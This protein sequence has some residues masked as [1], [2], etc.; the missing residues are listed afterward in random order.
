MFLLAGHLKKHISE[1][2]S[3]PVSEFREWVA[4]NKISPIGAVRDDLRI[5][6]AFCTM[7][8]ATRPYRARALKV[9]DFMLNF[10]GP[11]MQT[12]EEQWAILSAFAA[13]HNRKLENG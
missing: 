5:A 6:A 3:L 10:Q 8:N 11:R 7:Y 4:Y 1:I 12:P 13:K 2:E 9:K